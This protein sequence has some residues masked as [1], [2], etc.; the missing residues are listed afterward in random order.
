[1]T[2]KNWVTMAAISAML[3]LTAADLQAQGRNQGDRQDRGN[4]P[5][6]G[7]FDPAQMRERMMNNW[8]ETLEITD[9][10]EWNAVQPLVQKVMDARMQSFAGMGRGMFGAPRRGGAGDQGQQR[11][12][13]A[14]ANPAADALE[15]A[16]EAKASKAELKAAIAK[17]QEARKAKQAELETAQ[18]N[19]RKVLTA[20]QEALA[21][22]NGLL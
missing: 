16:V 2:I 14:Q 21:T 19:L 7:N 12:F 3:G 13:G 8:K 11:R 6:R 4:R 22:L 17:F 20:R 9:D 5:E 1:M 15:K 10:T 18:E